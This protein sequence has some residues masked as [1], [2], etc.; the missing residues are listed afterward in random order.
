[1][2]HVTRDELVVMMLVADPDSGGDAPGDEELA[3]WSEEYI[4]RK[5]CVVVQDVAADVGVS[6]PD[7][8]AINVGYHM[9]PRDKLRVGTGLWVSATA[10]ARTRAG[11]GPA[12]LPGGGRAPPHTDDAGGA[13][14]SGTCESKVGAQGK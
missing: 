10:M 5:G 11:N 14:A 2:Q 7:L 9:K 12:R 4:V 8:I 13:A 6:I 1:M 3:D